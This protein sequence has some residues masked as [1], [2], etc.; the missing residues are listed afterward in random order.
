MVKV[1]TALSVVAGL[2]VLQ[3]V[4]NGA[5]TGHGQKSF[6]NRPAEKKDSEKKSPFTADFKARATD[7]LG[8]WHVP[9]VSVAV[10]DGNDIF[11]KVFPIIDL[12]ILRLKPFERLTV[13]GV[14][15]CDSS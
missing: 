14:W 9:G 12:F 4:A 1:Q 2:T 13:V 5:T 8:Q 10:V 15:T 3:P 7:I 6:G 11:A